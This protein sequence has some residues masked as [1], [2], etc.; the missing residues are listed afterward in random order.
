MEVVVLIEP[1]GEAN[2]STAGKVVCHWR[3]LSLRL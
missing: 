1:P 3:P 2:F